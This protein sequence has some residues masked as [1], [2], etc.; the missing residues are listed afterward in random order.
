ME[1]PLTTNAPTITNITKTEA[2][3]S[4]GM[5]AT[6]D[7]HS[8]QAGVEMLEQGK[9]QQSTNYCCLR[10]VLMKVVTRGNNETFLN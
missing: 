6:K 4:R 5:V 10:R 8:T 7:V 3:A 9:Q 2:R 1:Y